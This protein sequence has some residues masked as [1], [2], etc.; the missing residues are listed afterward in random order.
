LLRL[1]LLLR[2]TFLSPRLLLLLV[3]LLHAALLLGRRIVAVAVVAVPLHV[4]DPPVVPVALAGSRGVP[5]HGEGPPHGARQG[6]PGLVTGPAAEPLRAGGEGPRQ[7]DRPDGQPFPRVGLLGVGQL[8]R[9]PGPGALGHR[10]HR[11]RHRRGRGGEVGV[12][13][14]LEQMDLAPCFRETE[15][16]IK[17]ALWAGAANQHRDKIMDK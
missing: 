10:R 14:H 6:A 4:V 13:I 8:Q 16:V 17:E 7:G 11:H 2:P 3:L 9:S 5:P 15:L 1:G 12:A